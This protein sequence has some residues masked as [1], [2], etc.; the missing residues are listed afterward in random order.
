MP[1][2]LVTY[3]IVNTRPLGKTNTHF[4]MCVWGGGASFF[5]SMVFNNLSSTWMCIIVQNLT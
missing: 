1:K 4:H 2:L 3:G 5:P